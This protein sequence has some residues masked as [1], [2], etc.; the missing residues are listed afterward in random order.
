MKSLQIK[1]AEKEASLKCGK[2]KIEEIED[3]DSDGKR[4]SIKRFFGAS[5]AGE[6]TFVLFLHQ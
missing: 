3:D 4:N 2:R 1:M 5:K 6:E